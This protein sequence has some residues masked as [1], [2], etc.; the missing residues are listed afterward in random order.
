MNFVD[1]L[2]IFEADPHTKQVVLIGE[3]GGNDEEDAA[4]YITSRMTKPVIAYIAGQTAPQGKKMGHAGAIIERG[5]DGNAQRKI[6]AL[7]N[8]RVKVAIHLEEIYELI[9]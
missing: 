3:I 6:T 2:D 7:Q 4:E 1:I 5:L 9:I 8:S